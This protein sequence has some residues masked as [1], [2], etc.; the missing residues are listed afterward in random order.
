MSGS[1]TG[2]PASEQ[3]GEW[4]PAPLS[5]AQQR[6]WFLDQLDPGKPFSNVPRAFRIQGW[7]DVEALRRSLD[8]IRERHEVLR[9]VFRLVDGNLVQVA[10]APPFPSLRIIDLGKLPEGRRDSEALQIADDEARTLFDLAQ[11]PLLRTT[12]LR[13]SAEEYVL[14]VTFHQAVCDERSFQI[15]DRELAA[16]YEAHHEGRPAAL[17]PLPIQYADFAIWQRE[18]I[19]Q[20][21]L[22]K[23]I[24]YWK[25]Q[26]QGVPA[27]LRLP[28]SRHRPA[29]R[30]YRGATETAAFDPELTAGIR[31]LCRREGVSLFVTLLAAFQILLRRHSGRGDITVGS[32]VDG[33]DRR[34]T[35]G[36]IG[37]FANTLAFRTDISDDPTFREA[38]VR[39]R[40]VVIQAHAHQELPFEKLV[41]ELNPERTLSRPP[42]FQVT[43]NLLGASGAPLR[44]PELSVSPLRLG[45][46]VAR[47]DLALTFAD[48]GEEILASLQ[49]NTDLFGARVIRRMLSRLELLLSGIVKDPD[50]RL[51]QLPLMT[52]GERQQAIVEWNRT[53]VEY[54]KRM[55][56]I[57]LFEQQVERSPDA[58]A[59]EFE[60]G[61]LT[62]GE[63]NRRSN[64]LARYLRG[65]GVGPEIP[66]GLCMKRS[67]D[68]VVGLLGILKAG[69]AYV[70]L[71]AA[72]PADRLRYMVEDSGASLVLAD[73]AGAASLPLLSARTIVPSAVG[74]AIA[75]ESAENLAREV[76]PHNLVYVIYTSGSTGKPKA[77][78]IEHK[79]LANYIQY[80]ASRFELRAD[81]RVLQF[82]SL[83]FD[84]AAEE[85]FG[86]LSRGATLVLRTEGM[87]ATASS[88]FAKCRE[89]GITVLDLPTSYW[90]ELAAAAA[91]ERLLLPESL[92][93]VLIGGEKALPEALAQWR[94][95][96]GDRV[97]LLNLYGPAEATVSTTVWDA[98]AGGADP[99]S[100]TVPIGRPIANT[101]VYV[102]DESLEPVPI[103][104]VGEL[105]VG[106]A[107]LARGYRNRPDLTAERF[108]PDPFRRG[109]RLYRTGDRVRY[110]PDGDLEY[111]SRA[112]E[113]IKLRG[114]RVEP[115]EVEAELRAHPAVQ[116]AAVVSRGAGDPRLVAYLVVR[117]KEVPA[118]AELRSFLKK[119][120]PEFMIPSTFVTLAALPLSP[121]GKTDRQA[122]PQPDDDRPEKEYV[123]P[124][125]DVEIKLAR[126]W[127]KVLN[128]ESV[129]AQDDFFELGGHSLLAVRL[130]SQIEEVFD[131]RLPLTVIFDAPTVGRLASLLRQEGWSP[132]WQPLVSI[133]AGGSRSPLFLVHAI[134][135]NVLTY[136]YLARHLGSDQPVYAL[137]AQGLDGKQ[138]PL[139][140]VEDIAAQYVRAIRHLQPQGPYWLG[141]YSFGGTVAFEMARQ[142]QAAGQSVPLVAL[143][144]TDNLPAP[145]PRDS[146]VVARKLRRVA[147]RVRFHLA[148][149]GSLEPR[150]RLPYLVEKAQVFFRWFKKEMKSLYESI[151]HP[152]PEAVRIV[153]AAHQEALDRYV[154]FAYDGRVVLF[155]ASE[156]YAAHPDLG[157][158]ALCRGGLEIIEVPGGHSRIIEEPEVRILAH[159]LSRSLRK[160]EEAADIPNRNRPPKRGS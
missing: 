83:S 36:L 89:W 126:L 149:L 62:Y 39:V 104:V 108:V 50:R 140:R 122:L 22:E 130:L 53:A 11:G 12:L 79:S 133:Q 49:Y 76:A 6:L 7:L 95:V 80:V 60:G 4:T 58:V 2:H 85:V 103:G 93:L 35:E 51:S 45:A 17:P 129:G 125:D 115:G 69:G 29:E 41:E 150:A 68:L 57:R 127:E 111:L 32:T 151:R 56:V 13:L 136:R 88:F 75:A 18:R 128:V 87:I 97:R 123:A 70:P 159:E 16:L 94:A 1:R 64:R 42:L 155:R 48:R 91:A 72:Y 105:Y 107:G 92:R 99:G 102:L 84:V 73:G 139:R 112:D 54:P 19:R 44:L 153:N 71:D 120:L 96:A 82:A 131:R 21:A 147:R 158:E 28:T 66:V 26:L 30:T 40:D 61:F 110:R 157:W 113:Q 34:D 59:V 135:G 3:R 24:S 90:H 8:T 114:I 138:A 14:L 23:Q 15:F 74:D 118:P 109:E 98:G 47:Y 46:E 146:S 145:P 5:Y 38:L 137:Q 63:L 52:A 65:A 77:V 144:D 9:S 156:T 154:P 106:G 121:N 132:S 117:A 160:T 27:V 119:T 43:M 143:I 67:L 86:T 152:L 31:E 101:R 116:E 33:R 142:L 100:R 148:A 78:E 10:A 124:R 20:G 141:G 81:D 25:R 37:L 55:T 134:G